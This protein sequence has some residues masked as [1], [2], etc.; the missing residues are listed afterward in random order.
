MRFPASIAK[1]RPSLQDE[2]SR[3]L[4]PPHGRT[5][6]EDWPSSLPNCV[7][8]SIKEPIFP[9]ICPYLLVSERKQRSYWSEK[10][11]PAYFRTQYG[12]SSC[13]YRA[14][15]KREKLKSLSIQVVCDVEFCIETMIVHGNWFVARPL[16]ANSGIHQSR[17]SK[18]DNFLDTQHFSLWTMRGVF[19]IYA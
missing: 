19:G 8:L 3:L 12:D 13:H 9:A 2:R 7:L 5:V 6:A 10:F 11:L 18:V 16:R 17:A 4:L 1:E 14:R 15:R